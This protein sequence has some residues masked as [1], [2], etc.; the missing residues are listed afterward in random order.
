MGVSRVK[1]YLCAVVGQFER[2]PLLGKEGWLRIK[3]MLRS[4]LLI[5]QTGWSVSKMIRK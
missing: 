3:E 1:L 2:I 5:A 4:N